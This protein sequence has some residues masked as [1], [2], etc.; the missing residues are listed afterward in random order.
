MAYKA[1]VPG[2][3]AGARRPLPGPRPEGINYI[4]L[5]YHMLKPDERYIYGLD[6]VEIN[7][8]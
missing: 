6:E 4:S 1:D 3:K 7:G 2:G 5:I 8:V